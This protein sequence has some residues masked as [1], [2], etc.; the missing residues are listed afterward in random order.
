[1]VGCHRVLELLCALAIERIVE[2]GGRVYH[3]DGPGVFGMNLGD[4]ATRQRTKESRRFFARYAPAA[5]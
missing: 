5:G 4:P 3:G 1:M 2:R